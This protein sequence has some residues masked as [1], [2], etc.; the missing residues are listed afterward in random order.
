[1]GIPSWVAKAGIARAL[2]PAAGALSL[3]LS[4]L[5]ISPKKP[6]WNDELYSWFFLADPSFSHM[7]AA[8]NDALNNTPIVYF[9]T[10]WLWSS[11]FGASELS[12]RLFSC[13]GFVA[14]LVMVW[15][16]LCKA[17][18]H[19][20]AG[21]GTLL[22][23]MTSD[24]VIEQSAE[25]RMYGLFA[26]VCAAA[27]L[28]YQKL[29]GT[30]DVSLRQLL[31][32]ALVHG[33]IVNTHL[34]GPFYSLAIL[35]ALMVADHMHRRRR[36]RV[37]G[38]VLLGQATFLA[39]LPAF[40]RQAQA[41]TPRAWM[42]VPRVQDFFDTV[43]LSSPTF[44][45][46]A[47]VSALV[48]ILL[49]IHL[50]GWQAGSHGAKA[51]EPDLRRY[52]TGLILLAIALM[53]V[54]VV[55]WLISRTIKPIFFARYLIPTL[56]S[57]SIILAHIVYRLISDSTH[58]AGQDRAR[59]H[60]AGADSGP[61]SFWDMLPRLMLAGL[62]FAAILVPALH[63]LKQPQKVAVWAADKTFGYG[64][65]PV[66]VQTSGGFLERYHYA[67]DRNR[68]YFVLDEQAAAK[69]E[70]GVFGLQEYKHMVAFR[71]EYPESVGRQIL[72][73]AG[74]LARFDRFLAIELDPY[75]AVC[76]ARVL[77]LEH[78]RTW[79][80][81][82]CSQ[83]L[84]TRILNNRRYHVTELG[85]KWGLTFL[86]VERMRGGAAFEPRV[87]LKERQRNAR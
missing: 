9:A 55:T 54:P 73:S 82:Q 53:A 12:L 71:R 69:V 64:D 78:A 37:Y 8:Y 63:A 36:W 27:A 72:P 70:S 1:M 60:I 13:L 86:L 52:Q 81:M 87:A 79:T 85:T 3:I 56:I 66:A 14:A 30:P 31:A 80:D 41:G 11:V 28:Q 4:C 45:N 58:S 33:L 65:L 32:V 84:E 67:S 49:L 39:Y 83:W 44:V 46:V 76:P 25:A 22:V 48:L 26:A 40:W 74:F 61:V 43:S 15:R 77:G 38:A 21:I 6:Y 29:L 34:F 75:N 68:Y 16:M 35:A 18:G 5:L 50:V 62:L 19:W 42:P 10:G 20:P 57:Y 51:T 23:F 17:Y 47:F 24:L 59:D 7:W 2:A